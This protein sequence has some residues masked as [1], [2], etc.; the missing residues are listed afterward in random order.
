MDSFPCPCGDK[1]Q[2]EAEDDGGA[3]GDVERGGDEKPGDGAE[4]TDE[5]RGSELLGEVFVEYAGDGLRHGEVGDNQDDA[6]KFE[7]EHDTQ[8]DDDCHGNVND[9]DMYVVGLA[10]LLVEGDVEQGAPE[11]HKENGNCQAKDSRQH[12]LFLRDGQNIAEKIRHQVGG[13][14]GREVDEEDAN[15]HAC[16]P[17][18]ADQRV[19][20][21]LPVV[22]QEKDAQ[23]GEEREHRG[24]QHGRKPE[25]IGDSQSAERG[26]GNAATDENHPF[27][28]DVST[29]ERTTDAGQDG[30]EQGILKKVVLQEF[31]HSFSLMFVCFQYPV[32]HLSVGHQLYRA[33]VSLQL[34]GR[35]QVGWVVV[36]R[37]V[38]AGDSF[39]VGADGAQV[40]R[41]HD[42][43]QTLVQFLE[44]GVELLFEVAVHVGGGFV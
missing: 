8:R 5:G 44:D 23:G 43:A 40:V 13:I 14:A 10:I 39:D 20:F 11:Q 41:H 42:D 36:Q 24:S 28:D 16:R 6:G 2:Q 32:G 35:N 25:V 7:A 34:F 4:S 26:V 15:C 3:A 19:F 9:I 21:Q 29:H 38:D 1:H 27:G 18:D 12:D 33:M 31:Q 22:C 37:P 17:E 30:A